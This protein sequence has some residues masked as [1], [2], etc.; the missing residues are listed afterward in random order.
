M[1]EGIAPNVPSADA[2]VFFGATGDLTHKTIFPALQAP[3][4]RSNLNVPVIGVARFLSPKI[5]DVKH[6]YDLVVQSVFAVGIFLALASVGDAHT[7]LVDGYGCHRGSDRVSYHRHQGQFAGRT[8]KSKEDFL[9]ELRA[10]SRRHCRRKTTRL[11]SI[12]RSRRSGKNNAWLLDRDKKFRCVCL[13][14]WKTVSGALT[15]ECQRSSL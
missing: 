1:K 8:F 14:T 9:R 5:L 15:S 11:R 2:V 10:A 12:I 6:L 4:K 7:G 3:A 13:R